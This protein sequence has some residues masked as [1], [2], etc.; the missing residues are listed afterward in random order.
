MLKKGHK[1]CPLNHN[2]VMVNRWLGVLKSK[3]PQFDLDDQKTIRQ[4]GTDAYRRQTAPEY[5]QHAYL[6]MLARER[7]IGNY[8]DLARNPLRIAPQDRESMVSL[9]QELHRVKGYAEDTFYLAVS[10]ADRYLTV[11]AT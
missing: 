1:V 9:I 4:M 5:T 3:L 2:Q 11:L 8:F 10:I 6:D 7:A